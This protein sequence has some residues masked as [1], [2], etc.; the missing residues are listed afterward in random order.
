MVEKEAYDEND[1]RTS[2][3]DGGWGQP[4][5][6]LV[7]E[8]D[9]T[10]GRALIEQAAAAQG[11]DLEPAPL[12]TF[13]Q[14]VYFRHDGRTVSGEV[15]STR[16]GGNLPDAVVVFSTDLGHTHRIDHGI[17]V[18]VADLLPAPDERYVVHDQPVCGAPLDGG[19]RCGRGP[20]CDGK[21]HIADRRV[22]R[23]E[24]CGPADVLPTRATVKRKSG[25]VNAGSPTRYR[26]PA[27]APTL[28]DDVAALREEIE[29]LWIGRD[30]V[31]LAALRARLDRI[32]VAVPQ[33][34]TDY[35]GTPLW[36]HSCQTA[37]AQQGAVRPALCHNC[38]KTGQWQPL[39]VMSAG[40]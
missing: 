17:A 8:H 31:D 13:G 35:S 29:W 7:D 10:V 6:M 12:P 21:P 16:T 30:G 36:Q 15:R 24:V 32:A 39:Y 18:N 26:E 23:G 38:D 3:A 4:E 33:Q 22:V 34:A 1:R 11:I 27:P 28:A 14:T 20:A 19:Q 9:A 2:E 5:G 40:A 37:L 25:T